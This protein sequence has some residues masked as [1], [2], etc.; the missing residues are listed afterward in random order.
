MTRSRHLSVRQTQRLLLLGYSHNRWYVRSRFVEV[1][2]EALTDPAYV[3]IVARILREHPEAR[4]FTRGGFEGISL[5]AVIA[6]AL[7]A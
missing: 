5:P 4:D 7:A 2:Q 3:P 1:A 6:E